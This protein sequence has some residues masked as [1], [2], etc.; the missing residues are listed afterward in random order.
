[1][2]VNT[3]NIWQ[4]RTQ[5]LATP[6]ILIIL[7][8][9]GPGA[10]K[11]AFSQANAIPSGDLS[12]KAI[13]DSINGGISYLREKQ[14]KDGSWDE[15]PGYS[16]GS[17][18]LC[19]LSLLSTGLDKDDPT[20]AKA[21]VALRRPMPETEFQTYPISLQTMVFCQA[22]PQR[23]QMLIRRNV[24]WLIERQ[25]KT[26][27]VFNGGWA[28]VGLQ[29]QYDQVDNSNSQFAI[30]ALFEAQRVGIEIP[31]AVWESALQYWLR[32][33][34]PDGSWGYRASVRQLQ[35]SNS[36]S[37]TGSMTCAGIGA[38][39]ICA[40]AKSG[41]NAKVQ[42]DK[43]ECCQDGDDKISKCIDRGL[44][45]MAQH[46]SV[47]NN[48]GTD[49]S[50]ETWIF[51]YLYGLERVG[52][53][54]AHRFIGKN[55]WY[56]EGAD[57][58]LRR[59]GVFTKYWRAQIDLKGNHCVATAFALLFLSKGRRPVLVSKLRYGT[60]DSWNLHASDMLHLT[61]Y[62]EK[63]WN[64]PLIWQMIDSEKATV[65]DLLQ[66]PVLYMSGVRSPV[67]ADPDRKHRLVQA[68]RGYLEQGGFV[69]A[70]ALDGDESFETGFAALMKEVLPGE[71]NTLNLIEPNHPIWQAERPIPPEQLR[72]VYGIDFGCR[73]SVVFVPAYR[74][75]TANG[76]PSVFDDRP[77]L[78][79]LWELAV[80][81]GPRPNYSESVEKQ[82]AAGLDL[83]VNIL[84]YATNREMKF[85][86]EMPESLA[87]E[88]ARDGTNVQ[89]IHVALL[90]HSGGCS[91]A[92]RAVPHLLRTLKLE[93]GIDF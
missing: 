50:L 54:T 61:E 36:G 12:P 47:Q 34:N 1:M 56:R 69:F 32:M 6:L 84:A 88:I 59:K 67:P 21:L 77:S 39:V 80:Q 26:N 74:P 87:K 52:R 92:P 53:L 23:D 37:G 14:Q 93:C 17:T 25:F 22:D 60:D 20:V 62:T 81:S 86:E 91:C 57:F 73:T 55:D 43:I 10:V 29:Q 2:F 85:K 89:A 13:Q 79:C 5:K 19:A 24:D 40:G 31:E 8:I 27:N 49:V 65:D 66:T 7:I 41:I 48:P 46:F 76:P 15:Y 44:S 68:L 16:P 71:G 58:L 11:T 82:I 42:N 4:V 28:Y 72:P 35:E 33:Q 38:L 30:L 78:S 63:L 3:D 9:L 64:Q 51:Y 18:A 90:E 75:K 70:E 45:W 83:G